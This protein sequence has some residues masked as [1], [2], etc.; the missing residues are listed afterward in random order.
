MKN[1]DREIIEKYYK[2]QVHDCFVIAQDY[3]QR[4]AKNVKKHINI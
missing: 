3:H 1:I 2:E 4:N